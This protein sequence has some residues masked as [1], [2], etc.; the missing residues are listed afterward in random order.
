MTLAQFIRAHQERVIEDWDAFAAT[1][2]P[3]SSTKA[4]L[5]DSAAEILDAI[6][7]DMESLQSRQEQIDKS[8]GE[9]RDPASAM[10]STAREHAAARLAQKFDLNEVIAEYRAL[11]ASVTRRWVDEMASQADGLVVVKELTRFDEAIDESL[12]AAVKWFNARLHESEQCFRAL[13]NATSDVVYRMSADWSVMHELDGRGF[14]ADTLSPSSAWMDKYIHPEDQP[15]VT[16]AINTAVRNQR[17]FDLEHRVRR[18]DGTIGWTYSRAIPVFDEHGRLLE[19]FGAAADVTARRQAEEEVLQANQAKD[20][21]LA[22]LSHELRNPLAPLLTGLELLQRSPSREDLLERIVPMMDRQLSHLRRLVNDLL[23]VSRVSRGKIELQRDSL[24]LNVPV[25]AAVEQVRPLIDRLGHTL[26]LE[27]SERPLPV[28]GDFE[29]LVQVLANVLSNA[30]K[31]TDPGGTIT[32]T[33]EQGPDHVYVSVRDTGVGLTAANLQSVF[34]LFSQI[35]GQSDR[36][37]GLGIG[38]ALSRQLVQ[39]HGGSIEARSEGEGRGSEFLIR[40][41]ADS[42]YHEQS[43]ETAQ[44]LE[45]DELARRLLIVD[46][47]ADA[48]DTLRM[49]LEMKGHDVDV[50]YGG[51]E[52]LQAVD[53]FHPEMVFLDLGLPD[54]DGHEVAREIRALPAGNAIKLIAVTGWGQDQ[55]LARTKAAGFDGHL[56]KPVDADKLGLVLDDQQQAD[57]FWG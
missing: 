6:A 47:N 51:R 27:L 41:P 17:V 32:V 30:A 15:K 44:L 5:R 3:D 2:L 46:D 31:Y 7:S 20:E 53:R 48:A 36:D 56:I 50:A 21:F 29:R 23:D 8:Q 14:L 43:P 40:L 13:V 52:A 16:S 24:D 39:M 38:L 22:V 57:G 49:L 4:Q 33:T 42:T 54:L 10:Q 11:W 9:P 45:R 34:D 37:G 25:Q 19:W 12:A 35:T 26:H 55:D 18:A 1:M 28:S